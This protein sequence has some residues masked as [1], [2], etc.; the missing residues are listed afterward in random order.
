MLIGAAGANSRMRV[1]HHLLA[2]ARIG[3]HERHTAVAKSHLRHFDLGGDAV[4]H[5]DLVA[6]VELI[7]FARRE[8]Q[9]H[10]GCDTCP[11]L[12][13]PTLLRVTPN[14]VIPA[15]AFSFKCEWDGNLQL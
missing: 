6:P 13:Q 5:H 11:A 4:E 9:R 2:L 1:E 7:G 10:I 14:R 8:T 3:P 15:V 12:R